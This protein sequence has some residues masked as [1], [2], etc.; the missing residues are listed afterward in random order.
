MEP[1]K[2]S[3]LGFGRISVPFSVPKHSTVKIPLLITLIS[4]MM[5]QNTLLT[6]LSLPICFPV[7]YFW[8]LERARSQSYC[9]LKFLGLHIWILLI[10]WALHK[11]LLQW[12]KCPGGSAISEEGPPLRSSCKGRWAAGQDSLSLKYRSTAVTWKFWVSHDLLP[13]QLLKNALKFMS[14]LQF[15]VQDTLFKMNI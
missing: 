1:H 8:I 3:A 12:L 7:L 14:F 4:I 15:S 6:R 11:C 9:S 2:A 13:Y 5:Y 10:L